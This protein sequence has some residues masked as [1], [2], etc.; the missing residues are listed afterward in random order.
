MMEFLELNAKGA[1]SDPSGPG[2]GKRYL[3]QNSFRIATVVQETT[4][5]RTKALFAVLKRE[6][7]QQ[8]PLGAARQENLTNAG[9]FAP[10]AGAHTTQMWSLQSSGDAGGALGET[11]RASRRNSAR[12]ETSRYDLDQMRIQSL[13]TNPG[14]E[15]LLGLDVGGPLPLEVFPAERE[16]LISF[17]DARAEDEPETELFKALV[18]ALVDPGSWDAR[19][20]ARARQIADDMHAN[21]GQLAALD[22]VDA[23]CGSGPE[24]GV[25]RAEEPGNSG[26]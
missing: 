8:K 11:G 9:N 14:S 18:R 16:P 3:F 5:F 13:T 21:Y 7:S 22:S 19:A 17:F 26:E 1:Q 15:N 20:G 6:L 23:L 24:V 25:G 12:L 10:P 2:S 4:Q